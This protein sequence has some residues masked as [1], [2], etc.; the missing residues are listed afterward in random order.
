MYNK[1]SKRL[2]LVQIFLI[3]VLPVA[4]LYFKILPA[5]WRVILLAISA[6]FIYGIIRHEHWTHEDMGIRHDN[7]KKALPFYF[8]FTVLSIGALFLLDHKVNMPDI[9]TKIF[10]IKTFIF[11]LPISFFQEFIFRSFLMPRL[12]EIFRSNF[13][14]IFLNAVLFA[15]MHIIYPNL[16]IGLPLAFVSGIFFAWLYLKYPNLLLISLSHAILNATAVLLGFFHI[17]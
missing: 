13:T 16:G 14:V 3:F 4:V 8:F 12:K 5:D 9:N 2:I 1:P 11:F 6:L 7:F 15:L 10:F 17:S